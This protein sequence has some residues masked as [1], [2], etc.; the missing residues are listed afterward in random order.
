MTCQ[1][2]KG[3]VFD[4]V[5]RQ[6]RTGTLYRFWNLAQEEAGRVYSIGL[7]SLLPGFVH[8]MLQMEAFIHARRSSHLTIYHLFKSPCI[9]PFVSLPADTTISSRTCRRP[10]S[11]QICPIID[12][13]VS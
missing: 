6:H 10:I 7:V 12:F 13:V 3:A 11:K 8:S 4:D 1:V 9:Q 5:T 2:P